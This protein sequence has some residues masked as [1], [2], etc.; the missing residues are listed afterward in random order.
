MRVNIRDERMRGKKGNL[1]YKEKRMTFHDA[2]S[3]LGSEDGTTIIHPHIKGSADG[4]IFNA[5]ISFNVN[6]I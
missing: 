2:C 1:S 5:T 3:T 6:V 4:C